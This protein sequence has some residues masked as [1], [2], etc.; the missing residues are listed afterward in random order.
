MKEKTRW[1]RVSSVLLRKPVEI[2]LLCRFQRQPIPLACAAPEMSTQIE[3]PRAGTAGGPAR[4]RRRF[5]PS[6]AVAAAAAAAD[7][8]LISSWVKLRPD[9]INDSHQCQDL[10]NS[11]SSHSSRSLF[12]SRLILIGRSRTTDQ[13]FS[14]P[15][16][17]LMSFPMP[18]PT[19]IVLRDPATHSCNYPVVNN[20]QQQPARQREEQ[21]TIH[22]S[23]L[24]LFS[25]IYPLGSYKRSHLTAGT[26]RHAQ[27]NG[28]HSIRIRTI[29]V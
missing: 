22:C 9:P 17:P 6:H 20:E 7:F 3:N 1:A 28:E 26:C 4:L 8:H 25:V 29:D 23:A 13:R 2:Y 12:S 19:T 15:R 10:S 21:P 5:L 14:M 18:M 24:F 16:L 27:T 11:S